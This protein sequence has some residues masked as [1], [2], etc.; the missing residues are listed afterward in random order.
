MKKYDL[1]KNF[2][3]HFHVSNDDFEIG[4]KYECDFDAKIFSMSLQDFKLKMPQNYTFQWFPD[5]GIG[6]I[7]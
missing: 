7:L 4:V 1:M 3:G 2:S 6:V 5:I